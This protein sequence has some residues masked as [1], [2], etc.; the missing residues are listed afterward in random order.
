MKMEIKFIIYFIKLINNLTFMFLYNFKIIFSLIIIFFTHYNYS[1]YYI[2]YFYNL[3][4][5][6]K[7]IISPRRFELLQIP[8][9]EIILPL[10]YR[11]YLFLGLF[12]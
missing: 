7:I 12:Y 5:I 11:L 10:N 8:H 1:I 3:Y 4:F 6:F 2:I 9:Q